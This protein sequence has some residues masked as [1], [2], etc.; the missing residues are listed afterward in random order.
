MKRNLLFLSLFITA[1]CA[2]A[3]YSSGNLIVSF[4]TGTTSSGAYRNLSLQEYTTGTTG[5]ANSA[6]TVGTALS[7]GRM[8]DD[9]K[10]AYEGQIN[11]SADG[12]YIVLTGRNTT[13]GTASGTARLAPLSLVRI[14]K[15]KNVE[16][17]DFLAADLAFNGG[18]GRT[19][20]SVDGNTFFVATAATNAATG[21]R[22]ATFGSTT[23]TS[24]FAEGARSISIWNDEVVVVGG[25][26][27]ATFIS[28]VASTPGTSPTSPAPAFTGPTDPNN[29]VGLVS[30]DIDVAVPG[31]DLMYVAQRNSGI[32]KY[33]KN[34]LGVWTYI[35]SSNSNEAY[36]GTATGFQSMTGRIES[37]KPVL[38]AIKIDAA[39][40]PN[41]FKSN[42]YQI[43]DNVS[44]TGDWAA[45]GAANP[46]YTVIATS[47]LASAQTFRGV[48][49]A[50]TVTLST[51]SFEKKAQSWSLY[52]NPSKGTLNISS[53]VSGSFNV[54]NVLGQKVHQFKVENGSNTVNVDK[55]N[56]GTY[57]VEGANATQKLIIQK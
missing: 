35:S 27:P 47:D 17:S 42:L 19:V 28:G 33:Y 37:G 55:L 31:N 1:M 13:D 30:F 6:T 5:T 54:Y 52:P 36:I 53:E 50:P 25:N 32:H 34:A 15:N 48:T 9:R 56:S 20:A 2:R 21:I 40:T 29:Y 23:N 43:I 14:S 44:R 41:G 38:Y 10:V 4:N 12:R 3:Q 7:T 39:G 18:S 22:L 8:T 26:D 24:Y 57:F 46:T 11:T 51:A 45:G 16:T 49:F